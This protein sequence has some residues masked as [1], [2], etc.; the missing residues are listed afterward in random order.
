MTKALEKE[1]QSS[2][3]LELLKHNPSRRYNTEYLQKSFGS[4]N[5]KEITQFL[6]AIREGRVPNLY[7]T[8]S[9]NGTYEYFYLPEKC[10]PDF[11]ALSCREFFELGYL[12]EVNRL[13]F[14][15][16][17]LSICLTGDP[18]QIAI[19]DFR[20]NIGGVAYS[21]RA[22]ENPQ[23]QLRSERVELE[24][25]ARMMQRQKSLGF[26]IQR[27]DPSSEKPTKKTRALPR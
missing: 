10:L 24:S 8:K 16:L 1:Q 13:F 20:D 19:Y 6:K 12:Q 5:S 4:G 7:W 14:H 23:F 18:P 21:K 22:I 25:A 26:G 2:R 3:I 27:L 15:P 11:K 17:G 9:K